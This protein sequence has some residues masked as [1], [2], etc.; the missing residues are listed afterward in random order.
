MKKSCEGYCSGAGIAALL[1]VVSSFRVEAQVF[2]G[3]GSV[4]VRAGAVNPDQAKT[5]FGWSADIDAGYIKTPRLRVIVGATGFGAD[6]KREVSGVPVGG[7]IS[8]VGGRVGL[9]LDAFGVGRVAPYAVASVSGHNVSADVSDAGTKQLLEGFYVGAGLGAGLTFAIDTAARFAATTEVRRVY[10][11]NVSHW[12]YEVG[13]RW[14]PQGRRAYANVEREAR[15]Q[16]SLSDERARF[17][18]ERS[19]AVERQRLEAA[20]R[21]TAERARR[22]LIERE[23]RDSVARAGQNALDSQRLELARRDALDSQR[24]ESARRDSVE[25]ART[26]AAQRQAQ[27][28]IQTLRDRTDS[29]ETARRAETAARGVAE[30]EASAARA[31]AE[32]AEAAVLEAERKRYRA[33]LDLDRLISDVTEIKETERGIAIVLGQGLFA[34][35]QY[36]L[37]ERARAQLGTIAAVLDQYPERRIAVEGHTDAA[38]GEL[39]N[40]QLSEKRAEAVRAAMIAR[41][42]E[43][44]RIDMAGYGEGT[45]VAENDT[46]KGRAQNRRV[47]IIIIGARRPVEPP[48][49]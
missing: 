42:I 1:L 49:R 7:S 12:A 44:G 13:M 45:P 11:T 24:L 19:R 32:T 14:T 47:E 15:R 5:G 29:L 36:R 39:A 28:Q 8:S 41:G 43:P 20:Q 48:A 9:R 46:P 18:A 33:L 31:R 25:R 17:A 21:D 4:D 27:Q 3:F 10:V 22:D 26:D 16:Q 40:Q 35:G 23:R 37:S 38:G 30:A 2:P 34:S 6:V